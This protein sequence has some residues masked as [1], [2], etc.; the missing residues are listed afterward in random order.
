M[1]TKSER[2]FTVF[3]VYFSLLF[4]GCVSTLGSFNVDE[5]PQKIGVLYSR[6]PQIVSDRNPIYVTQLVVYDVADTVWS[7]DFTPGIRLRPKKP[8]T[9][10]PFSKT[11]DCGR[12]TFYKD[13]VLGKEYTYVWDLERRDGE[14]EDASVVKA[15][16]T[17]PHSFV[18][19]PTGETLTE[20]LTIQTPVE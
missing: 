4:L 14:D 16:K 17:I 20:N 10:I 8:I 9:I 15:F 19:N 5:D 2:Y 3:L 13:P 7:I 18:W 11:Q 1:K 6:S 12:A